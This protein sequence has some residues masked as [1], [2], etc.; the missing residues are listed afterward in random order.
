M[1]KEKRSV[2]RL[3]RLPKN[4]T[5]MEMLR[6]MVQSMPHNHHNLKFCVNL[7]SYAYENGGITE[8]QAECIRDFACEY[9]DEIYD[10]LEEI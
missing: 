6:F 1:T 2:S 5:S 10:E 8:R 4:G 9:M 7:L 3:I